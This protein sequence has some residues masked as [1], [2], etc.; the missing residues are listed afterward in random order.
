MDHRRNHE[1]KCATVISL[2]DHWRDFFCEPPPPFA[3]IGSDEE[4]PMP[5]TWTLFS[6]MGRHASVVELK[7]CL[8]LRAKQSPN[9][10]K[11][12]IA[13]TVNASWRL[14]DRPTKIRNAHGK[15]VWKT[16]PPRVKERVVPSWVKPRMANLCVVGIVFDWK[17]EIA[18]VLPPAMSGKLDEF[19]DQ[20]GTHLTDRAA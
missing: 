1:Q 2:L 5:Q 8:E 15:M 20:H 13:Y 12:L 19:T 11:H 4:K 7:R 14:T 18:L 17:R 3:G 6:S 10:Y 9:H 16:P